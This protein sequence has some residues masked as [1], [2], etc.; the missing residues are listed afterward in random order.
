MDYFF[1]LL[2]LK[3]IFLLGVIIIGISLVSLFR[4][5]HNISKIKTTVASLIL[6]YYLCILL[7]NIIGM[8]TLSDL[9]RLLQSGY[10]IFNPNLHLIPFSDGISLSFILNIFLFIPL[11]FLCPLICRKYEHAGKTILIGFGLS[12]FVEISQLFTL[13]RATD[14]DDLLT[15]VTGTIIGYLIFKLIAKLR[16]IK[17]HSTLQHEEK[18]YT[19]YLLIIIIA[20]AIILG[21]LS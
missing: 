13:A 16:I 3:P 12:L 11:G 18:D 17:Q 9:I 14:I 15:N 8:P 2:I 20:S 21:F 7:I 5:N 10:S 19:K 6:Y 1:Y 4:S